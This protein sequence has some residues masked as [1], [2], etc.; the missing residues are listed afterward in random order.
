MSRPSL[1]DQRSEQILDAYLTCVAQFGLEGATQER[2]AAEAGVKRP[3]LRHNLG[4]KTQMISALTAHVV[5]CFAASTHALAVALAEI[6][7]PVEL[8][9][10]IFAKDEASDPRLMLAWQAL[11]ASVV[12]YPEMREPLLES[13]TRFLDV[14]GDALKRVAPKA[15]SRRIRV[16]A[17][18][19]AAPYMALDAMSPLCPPVE[20]QAELKQAACLLAASLEADQ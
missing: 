20:W 2:I 18:G 13:L 17:Q 16:V 4:N 15:D 9:E 11:T 12:E 8:V 3:L 5:E 19:I 1:K 10:L 14:I 6:S 7:T